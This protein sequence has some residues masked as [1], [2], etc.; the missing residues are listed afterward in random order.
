[1]PTFIASELSSSDVSPGVGEVGAVLGV[2]DD[3]QKGGGEEETGL[4]DMASS[5][6]LDY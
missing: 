3:M 1:M 4:E 2:A 5:S 6:R